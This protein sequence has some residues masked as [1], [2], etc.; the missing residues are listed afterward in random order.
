M[1][2]RLCCMSLGQTPAERLPIHNCAD[3]ALLRILA[4]ANNGDRPEN[5]IAYW[6]SS[7]SSTCPANVELK[8][9]GTSACYLTEGL[10]GPRWPKCAGHKAERSPRTIKRP[11]SIVF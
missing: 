3:A 5:A 1:K 8:V 4:L 9:E 2:D 6:N 10:S 7:T 11:Y